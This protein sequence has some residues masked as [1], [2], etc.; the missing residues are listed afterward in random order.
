MKK[1]FSILA[2][3]LVA[4]SM[5]AADYTHSFGANVGG[6]MG[7]SYKGFIFG[8]DNLALQADLG[9]RLT[10]AAFKEGS[11][12]VYTFE[13]NPNILYQATIKD[14]SFGTLDWVAGG[15]V[16][17]GLINAIGN[18][19][20]PDGK[21]G[22]NAFGGLELCFSDAPLALGFD[23]RPGYGLGFGS[24]KDEDFRFNY[25]YNFFDWS[26]GASLRYRIP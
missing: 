1:I 25:H 2:A 21:F 23:F 9:V 14:F 11:N 16:S 4:G 3:V 19:Q 17:L 18:T 5:M 26:L 15:G 13:A 6:M 8:M 10:E 24:F 20:E 22:I 7:A 12:G